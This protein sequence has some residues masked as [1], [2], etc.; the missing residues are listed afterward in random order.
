MRPTGQKRHAGTAGFTLVE[1]MIVVGILALLAA[2]AIP[3][4]VRA[5]IA[6]N[7]SSAQVTLKSISTALENY[8]VL[9]NVYPANTSNLIGA[10]PPYLNVD[11]FVG[12]HNGYTFT[13]TTLTDYSYLITASPMNANAGTHTYTIATG[14]VIQ[15]N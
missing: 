9:N 4:L 7:E 15:Q 5:K 13:S 10:T 6:A 2:I 8:S 1:I 12:T 11:Y 14:G 3:N